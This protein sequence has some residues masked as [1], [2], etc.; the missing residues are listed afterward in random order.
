MKIISVRP[1]T[2]SLEN[3]YL[4]CVRWGDNGGQDQ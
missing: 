4:K 1:R 3:I 2:Q